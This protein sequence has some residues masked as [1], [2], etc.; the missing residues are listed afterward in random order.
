MYFLIFLKNPYYYPDISYAGNFCN[1]QIN[2]VF[3]TV[4]R[5]VFLVMY[6]ERIPIK[7]FSAGLYLALILTVA[8]GCKRN[9]DTYSSETGESGPVSQISCRNR[10]GA[11]DLLRQPISERITGRQLVN[12][13]GFAW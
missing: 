9:S 7:I 11:E 5:Y 6:G 10:N 12:L 1:D 13:K 4:N 3:I 2:R 8:S